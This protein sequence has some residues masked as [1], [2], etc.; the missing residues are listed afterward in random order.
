MLDS[1]FS[2]ATAFSYTYEVFRAL[3]SFQYQCPFPIGRADERRFLLRLLVCGLPM[4]GARAPRS[5]RLAP[6]DR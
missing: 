6:E 1:T 3:N 4:A 5:P 2:N